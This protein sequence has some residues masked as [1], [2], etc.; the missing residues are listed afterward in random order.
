MEEIYVAW[1]V[2]VFVFDAAANS[3]DL[4]LIVLLVSELGHMAKYYLP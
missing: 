3:Q 1:G 2:I 4:S